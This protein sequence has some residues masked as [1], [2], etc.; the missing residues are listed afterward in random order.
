MKRKRDIEK[1]NEG[2]H[3][4]IEKK[5]ERERESEFYSSSCSNN[6]HDTTFDVSLSTRSSYYK[7]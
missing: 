5:Q 1:K 7:R 2:T 3:S 4:N 6:N